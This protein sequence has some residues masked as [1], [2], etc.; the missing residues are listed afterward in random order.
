[1]AKTAIIIGAGPAGLTA[2]YELLTRTD[3]IPIILE[4][5]EEI[6]G[7]SRTINY[8]GNRMD[9]GGHRFFSK[10][11][12]VMN[13]WLKIMPLEETSNHIPITYHRETRFISNHHF[14]EASKQ[15]K[16][17]DKVML[18][19]KRLSRIYFLRKF[20]AYPIQLSFDTLNK[21][22][23]IR[24]TGILVSYIKARFFPRKPET[25]LE[26]F[27]INRFGNKLYKLFFKD[28]TEKV[29]GVPCTQISA[30]WGAQRVKG[31]SIAKAISHALKSLKTQKN[32]KKTEIGQKNVETS[33]IEQF[34]YPKYGPGQ[35]W[36]EVARQVEEMGGRILK[37]H[38]V[39]S[40]SSVE[41]N[42]TA[43]EAF[44]SQNGESSL[45]EGDYFFST[46]P[47]QE[48]I[49]ALKQ[50]APADI[51]EIAAG[52]QY[53]DF[54]TVG[55]LLS[56]M[57][58]P[59]KWRNMD[60]N[61]ILPDTWIYIQEKDVKVGRLQIFNNWSPSMVA[62]PGNVWIGM[63]YFCTVGDSFW[64]LNDQEIQANAF[65]E[66]EKMGL[67]HAKDILDS[68]VVRMEK[69]YPAYFGTYDR[70]PQVQIFTD[71]FKNLFLVGRNGM[72]KYNNSDHSM[73]T[74][75]VA[76]DNIILDVNSKTNIWE[77][78]TEQEYHEE[79]ET[80]NRRPKHSTKKITNPR[81]KNMLPDAGIS[82][83]FKSF[84]FHSPFN[85]R[86]IFF[87]AIILLAQFTLFKFLYPYASF[88]DGDSYSFI[89]A[90]TNNDAINT[91]PIGYSKFLRLFSVISTSDTVLVGFQYFFLQASGLAFLFTLFYFYSPSTI[92][93]IILLAFVTINPVFL[94][95]SNYVSS[96]SLF[97]SLSVIWIT[98]LIWILQKPSLPIIFFQALI[99]YFSFIVRYNAL[100]YPLITTLAFI[101]SK[102][103]ILNKMAGT[104]LSLILITAFVF[105]TRENYFKLTGIRQ[106]S[107]FSG[108]QMANNALYAYRY[109]D[110]ADR[111][112]VPKRFEL[113]DITVKTYFD[114]SRDITKHPTESLV[115]NTWYMWVT[116]S[117]LR[118]YMRRQFTRDSSASKLKKWATLA[119]LYS[120]YGSWLIQTYPKSF[121][122]YYLCPNA[123]RYY[124]PPV[125]YLES[126]NM[127]IDTIYPTGQKWFDY[128]SAK[129]KTRFK[130]LKVNVL[131]GYPVF[132][133]VLNV[134]FLFSILSFLYLRSHR[135]YPIF[136][137]PLFLVTVFWFIH[138]SFSV[139]ASPIALRFQLFP[140]LIYFSFGSMV[141][142]YLIKEAKQKETANPV[143]ENKYHNPNLSLTKNI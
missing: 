127:G 107:P 84:L 104:L 86:S 36:E 143:V 102:Q 58:P 29:W 6:G 139:F 133:G 110:S 4:K 23:P 134:L 89:R 10:S 131:E 61:P 54:I 62:N 76:V 30:Q 11:D 105:S 90:A 63:E 20:F 126:F 43:V 78:N 83:S 52:L 57:P 92:L 106:F 8:K 66:L 81:I 77:I 128:K 118:E 98:L 18:V 71:R 32:S 26:D 137:R 132:V 99:L 19:R 53:R 111:K 140:I 13:W 100:I 120:D 74:A 72:H 22:G 37:S 31:I 138:F 48:F 80:F 130:D 55:V 97:F 91:Q 3:I 14:E 49:A 123:L 65:L 35:L 122:K 56:K 28:Y 51:Q 59:D 42:I 113:L 142:Q 67:A 68:T 75:M 96:D 9:I 121:V 95:L 85:R 2:A 45:F 69:T 109:V 7:I 136:A 82:Q 47:V 70:F 64:S 24:T 50:K 103:A 27:F 12:R 88:I 87:I 94:Y 44:N 108:W 15:A 41:N 25:N 38:D 119:P 117:P 40:I 21:L 115:A 129:I 39:R 17:A 125:E 33:L 79:K 116:H 73:L 101:L 34:L 5:S 46:M 135:K 16:D 141:I 93:K 1:M 60:S 114:T 124:A 112:P